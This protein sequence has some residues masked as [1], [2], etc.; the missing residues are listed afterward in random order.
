MGRSAPRDVERPGETRLT[1]DSGVRFPLGVSVE[2]QLTQL[3]LRRH[4]DDTFDD[5]E[6]LV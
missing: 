3:A 5:E 6:G 2:D 1:G 4:I